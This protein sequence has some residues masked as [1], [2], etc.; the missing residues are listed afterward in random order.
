[1][2]P[3]EAALKGAREIAFA[4]I[5]MTLTLAAVYAPIG[6][7]TG[8]TGRL[9]TEFALTLAG[10]VLVSGFVALTLSPM[11]C[12]Q[13]A[14]PSGAATTSSTAGS[15]AAL[16][17]PDPRLPA[18]AAPSRS[19]SRAGWSCWLAAGRGA[20]AV[21]CSRTLPHGAVADR[22]PRHRS[23]ASASRPKAR[24]ST[25]PTTTRKQIEAIFARDAGDRALL[26]GHRLL[27]RHPGRS[28]SSRLV[29]WEQAA[30][31]SSRTIADEPVAQAVR[32]FPGVLA[33]ADQP[34]LARP[35]R[36][37]TSRSQFVLQTSQPY[38]EL[39]ACGRRA[40]G[41][42]ARQSRAASTST[43]I[44]SSTSRELKVDDRPREGGRHGHRRRDR[45]AARSRP[46]SAAARS[47]AS[48]A[49]A[50][51]TTSS[52]RSPTSTAP[53]RDDLARDLRA[54]PRRRDGAARPTWSTIDETVA[55]QGAQ[56]LQQ[57]ALGDAHRHPGA[58]LHAGR[59]ARLPGARPQQAAA[60]DRQS[61]SP[62]SRASS[63]SL[64][65]RPLRH[66]RAGAGLHLP[67]AGGAVRELHR[68]VR[69]SC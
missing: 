14:A 24:R 59:G 8:R 68:P 44:S 61:T 37:S 25:T 66:L 56:P 48:S 64:D 46:C 50:S 12:S 45:S 21:S 11:M 38:E 31:A 2:P 51:S 39:Q 69:S 3:V 29:D 26:R 28:P 4:V 42:G 18:R 6:F 54:R 47:P 35:E 67:G 5:A 9:F 62:A 13:A 30:R 20:S 22:G 53:T 16:E 10:A 19:R 58:G 32:A 60:G 49:T 27:R 55:P 23:S 34:A 15:S 40:A 33:F 52:C 7:Q 17:R 41:G 1:M 57:A 36:R 63:R 43:P 65:Q